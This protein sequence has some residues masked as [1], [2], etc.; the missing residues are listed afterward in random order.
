MGTWA[1]DWQ[2]DYDKIKEPIFV[3]NGIKLVLK[4]CCRPLRLRME[5]VSHSSS[6]CNILF[7][8]SFSEEVVFVLLGRNGNQ[9]SV[10]LD[11][12]EK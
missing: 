7:S 2:T 8:F 10:L 5:A 1:T 6:G 11:F 12:T 4:V 9:I 3:E